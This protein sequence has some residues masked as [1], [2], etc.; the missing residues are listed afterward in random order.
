MELER[1][2]CIELCEMALCTP[3]CKD[4]GGGEYVWGGYLFKTGDPCYIMRIGDE[5]EDISTDY[6]SLVTLLIKM[7]YAKR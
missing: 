1:L 6:V 3:G 7:E 5:L 4:E 2:L